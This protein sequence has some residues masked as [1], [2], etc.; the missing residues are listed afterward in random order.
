MGYFLS[1]ISS[2]SEHWCFPFNGISWDQVRLPAKQTA[3]PTI[4][5]NTKRYRANDEA[6]ISVQGEHPRTPADKVNQFRPLAFLGR[7]RSFS[8]N[9]LTSISLTDKYP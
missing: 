8:I 9:L 7:K 2:P 6:A 5:D 4:H 3:E 1:E